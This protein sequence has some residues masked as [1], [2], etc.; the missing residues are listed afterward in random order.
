RRAA[1]PAGAD[2]HRHRGAGPGEG[3]A[4]A[5]GGDGAGPTLLKHPGGSEVVEGAL[6][7]GPGLLPPGPVR[8]R[9][10][11]LAGCPPPAPRPRPR[12]RRPRPAG[13]SPVTRLPAVSPDTCPTY[14]GERTALPWIACSLG[15][16]HA[17]PA[18]HPGR[19][20]RRRPRDRRPRLAHPRRAVPP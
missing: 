5:A 1:V 18:D 11:P 7:A 10:R 6:S 17:P 16:T 3:G 19:R 15:S 4:V 2:P 14:T 9:P 13:R 8:R 12:P 20:G